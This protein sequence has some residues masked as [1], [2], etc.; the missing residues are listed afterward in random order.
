MEERSDRV[1]ARVM[2]SIAAAQCHFVWD[3]V[4][5]NEKTV[6][7]VC[8]D[9]CAALWHSRLSSSFCNHT[10]A[11]GKCAI[12]P[13]FWTVCVSLGV[14]PWCAQGSANGTRDSA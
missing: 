4:D 11:L 1:S 7:V 10:S 2:G 6:R 13:E 8:A 14:F 9:S 5:R 12:R 3:S